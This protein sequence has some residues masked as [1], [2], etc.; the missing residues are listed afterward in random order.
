MKWA[1]RGKYKHLRSNILHLRLPKKDLEREK[2]FEEPPRKIRFLY[3]SFHTAL[4]SFCSSPFSQSAFF[5][6]RSMH[7]TCAHCYCDNVCVSIVE[8]HQRFLHT[9]RS[10]TSTFTLPS[11]HDAVVHLSGRPCSVFICHA[12]VSCGLMRVFQTFASSACARKAPA[13]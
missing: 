12:T 4:L 3:I 9:S 6:Q 5:L 10:P 2:I 1:Q 13:A 8:R 11:H 7:L